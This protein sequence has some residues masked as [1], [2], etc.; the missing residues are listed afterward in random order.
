MRIAEV[1]SKHVRLINPDQTIRD[2]AQEMAC[3]DIGAL[4]V[5]ENNRLTGMITDRDIAI[6]AVAAGKGPDTPVRAVMTG[7]ARYC[8]DDEDVGA[9]AR[10]MAD[11]HLRRLP[12]LNREKRLMGIVSVDDLAVH[13]PPAAGRAL[14]GGPG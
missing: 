13:A 12:V 3:H 5:A 4:P 6:R 2:A 9:V 14:A 10:L 1:M 8:F 11:L 7:P